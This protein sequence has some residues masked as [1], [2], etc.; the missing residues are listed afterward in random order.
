M[1]PLIGYTNRL[2]ARPREQIEFKVSS[3]SDE[4]FS[5]DLIRIVCADPNPDGPGLIEHDVS[6]NFGGVFPSRIQ[7]FYPGSYGRV[8]VQA[9]LKRLS[10]FS[11]A[12]T[13]WPTSPKGEKQCIFALNSDSQNSHIEL[14][15]N[16]QGCLEGAI[17]RQDEPSFQCSVV[18]AHPLKSRQWYRVWFIH[19][20]ESSNITIG[21]IESENTDTTKQR[22]SVSEPTKRDTRG[23]NVDTITFAANHETLP[24]YH[25]NGKLE[26]P[27]IF[28]E[29]LNGGQ[30]VPSFLAT[31]MAPLMHWD[32]SQ[33]IST[34]QILDQG[35]LGCHGKLTN[36]PARGMT[37]SNW[38][39]SEMAWRHAPDQYGAI[40]FHDD[41]IYDFEWDTDF[42]FTVPADLPSGIYAARIR[43]GEHNDKIPFF[44]CPD[45][46]KPTARLCVLVSTFTYAIYGNH[47]RPDFNSTWLDRIQQWNAYPWN[48]A[49]NREYGL[50]TYNNHS[51]GSGIC[52][53][54]AKRPLMNMRPGY[55][56]FGASENGCSGL[57]H[58]QADSHL[59]TWLE[60]NGIE[61]DIV[62]D[63]EVHDM[64]VD[65][66]MPYAAVTTGTHPEYHT[67]QTLEAIAQ[68][69]SNAGNFMY[70]GGNGF[71]WK[72]S[73][74]DEDP[75]LMEIRRGEGGIRAWA[76]EPGEYYQA[77]DGSYG[78]LWRRN[79]QPPQ[80][81]AGIGF[82]AQGT[83]QG[84]YYRRSKAPIIQKETALGSE[85]SDISWV[86]KGIADD[87]LGDFGLCGGGAA[88]FELDRV[89]YRLGSNEN[90]QILASSEGHDDSFVLV[91][92]EQLTHIT[93]WPG[94]PVEDLLRAD[95]IYQH[96][97]S[98]GQLFATGSI[99][100]CGSLLHNNGDN[101]IS[102]L[103]YNV[104][105]KFTR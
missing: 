52:H 95:M 66:L 18:T 85:N 65:S 72:I 84:S 69:R 39:G 17:F 91:P 21:Y 38:D 25:F 1:I 36:S 59:I 98:G 7:P 3:Q 103:L 81:I 22:E 78:G 44:V 13:I 71:Y 32:F 76:A 70:L 104:V 87:I 31:Q 89:D 29:T 43:C 93:N 77:F 8:E 53:A 64:G 102:K 48:P 35:P 4:P 9:K 34:T 56:T 2:S 28:T 11:L 73:L 54:S 16:E 20:A 62:T 83:F 79:G 45:P 15:I 26:S 61:Y 41:D 58:F 50:S 90:I 67:Q 57:R 101:N 42:T 47:A 24:K 51:D 97:E 49:V 68:Y 86:F 46:T 55:I 99:T 94:E 88:G 92:E 63:Q 6:T 12:A 74:H 60:S 82:S 100:F 96:S 10:T 30:I 14:S 37:G 105:E 5:A 75:S 40:H 27:M 23:I 19:D 80:K 33:G